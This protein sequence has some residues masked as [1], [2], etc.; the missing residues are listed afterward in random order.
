MEPR[1]IDC[2]SM[3]LARR[4]SEPPLLIHMLTNPPIEAAE[5]T[6]S[7]ASIKE[8]LSKIKVDSRVPPNAL[9]IDGELIFFAPDER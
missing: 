9:E 3:S 7:A 2:S 6:L 1:K 5:D 4:I 8:I